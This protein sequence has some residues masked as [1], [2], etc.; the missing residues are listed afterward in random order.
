M[1]VYALQGDTLDELCARHLGTTAGGVVEATLNA[2]PGLAD[3]GVI[4]PM[5]TAV[6]LVASTSTSATA[7]EQTIK[8]WD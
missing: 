5:G 4:L 2:N 7:A 8:L 1:L 6:D 3:L